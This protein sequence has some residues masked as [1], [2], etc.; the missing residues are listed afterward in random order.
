M[1][2]LRPRGRS[3]PGMLG[4]GSGL[5]GTWAVCDVALPLATKPHMSQC[6]A[7]LPRPNA[8][9]RLPNPPE[10]ERPRP[11]KPRARPETG[12]SGD[13]VPTPTDFR[14]TSDPEM[15][16]LSGPGSLD[17]VRG[18]REEPGRGQQ[19]AHSRVPRL[20]VIGQSEGRGGA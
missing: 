16:G 8:Q 11:G 13:P 7:P 5:W 19:E 20:K 17:G 1:K 18:R 2:L 12:V 15:N 6:Q 10:L 3:G 9:T 4:V 14:G